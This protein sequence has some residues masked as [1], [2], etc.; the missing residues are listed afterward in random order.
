M[1][2]YSDVIG[3]DGMHCI[4]HKIQN[5]TFNLLSQVKKVTKNS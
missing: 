2:K 3:K 4:M 1:R 5:S